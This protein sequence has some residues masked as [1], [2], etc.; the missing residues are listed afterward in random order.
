MTETLDPIPP[1]PAQ[2]PVPL[3]V[4]SVPVKTGGPPFPQY[5]SDESKFGLSILDYFA[6]AA[7]AGLC[8]RGN[9]NVSDAEMIAQTAY[10]IAAYLV[11]ARENVMIIP[12][13]T[14]EDAVPQVV[15]KPQ[16]KVAG[17]PTEAT[18]GKKRV[19]PAD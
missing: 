15:I 19:I 14:P 1:E 18:L 13:P 2:Q 11:D 10:R 8:A 16:Q 17:D 7:T 4:Q 9:I 3:L 12:T 5:P 6:A